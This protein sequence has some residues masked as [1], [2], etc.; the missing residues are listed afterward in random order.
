VISAAPA[1]ADDFDFV[2]GS[3][4]VAHRRLKERL[5]NCSEWIEFPGTSQT[6]KVLGGSGNVEDNFLELPD[7]PYR[8]VALRSFDAAHS[9]WAIWWLDGR[10][11]WSLDAPVIG[12]FVNGVGLFYADGDF[13]G[14]PIRIRFT[15][16]R[17]SADALRWEQAFSPD[18]GATWET[19][20]TMDFAR[21]IG[22][23]AP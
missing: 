9:A 3:W 15:W 22:R 10:A 6:R 5:A 21:Q 17:I 1:G 14:K 19:N 4:Q 18:A 13:N 8:A 20:W 2:I 11:P 23:A 7:G 12:A 16:T